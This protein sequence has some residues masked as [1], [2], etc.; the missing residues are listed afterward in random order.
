MGILIIEMGGIVFWETGGSNDNIRTFLASI[1]WT[2]GIVLEETEGAVSKKLVKFRN[3]GIVSFVIATFLVCSIVLTLSYKGSIN[4]FLTSVKPP[5]HLPRTFESL[6][7][8]GIK[9]FSE[10]K[11]LK[12]VVLYEIWKNQYS[13]RRLI[14][15][16]ND[17]VRIMKISEV[18]GLIGRYNDA[19][20]I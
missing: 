14:E 19:K 6:V 13:L 2:I 9:T 12:S 7:V 8:S 5:E 11:Q 17:S 16:F 1:F 20:V 15:R 4:S 18:H 3:K 10:Q